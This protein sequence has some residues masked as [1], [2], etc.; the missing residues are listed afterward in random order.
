MDIFA[1][2]LTRAADVVANTCIS[3]AMM[4]DQPV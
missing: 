1:T 3:R 4:P 2:A